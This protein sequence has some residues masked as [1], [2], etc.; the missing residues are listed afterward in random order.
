MGEPPFQRAHA[1][2]SR[3]VTGCQAQAVAHN[4][5]VG[6]DLRGASRRSKR[7]GRYASNVVGMREDTKDTV[8]TIIGIACV[9]VIVG[10][11]LI[12]AFV[13]G[14]AMIG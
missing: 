3:M 10:L 5:G 6:F 12:G 14:A 4:G 11:A 7:A 8:G 1:T 2:V 13:V 9:A